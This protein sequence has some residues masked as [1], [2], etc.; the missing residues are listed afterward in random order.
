MIKMTPFTI[1]HATVTTIEVQLPKTNLIIVSTEKGY[2]MC[3]ALDV[4]L[5]NEKL[6]QREVIC[7][8]AIGVKTIEELLNAPLSDV[9]DAAKKLGIHVGMVGKE[10]I[11]RMI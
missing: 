3:G 1:E 10:A 7:G 8:R 9:T 4:G 2:I 11:M 5:I 6:A